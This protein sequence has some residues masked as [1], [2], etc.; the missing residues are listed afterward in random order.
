VLTKVTNTTKFGGTIQL[1]SADSNYWGGASTPSP[2]I[3][4]HA[5]DQNSNRNQRVK[6]GFQPA[7]RN[8]HRFIV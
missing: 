5:Y 6:P 2:G 7:V 1:M 4:T 3:A 8:A